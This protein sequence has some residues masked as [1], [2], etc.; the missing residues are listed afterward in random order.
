MPRK[1]NVTEDAKEILNAVRRLVRALRLFDKEAHSRYGLSTAQLFILHVLHENEGCSMNDL[2]AMT[3]TD[4]STASVIVQRLV[5]AGYVGRG[6]SE[7]D[8]R[9]VAL[10][11]TP[12]GRSLM[13]KSPVPVQ[14]RIRQSA[15]RMKAGDRT[16]LIALLQTFLHGMDVDDAEPAMLFE[17]AA[18]KRASRSRAK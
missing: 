4:Q 15:Q 12:S 13:A 3:A 2:A 7:R 9:H 8:R 18:P 5:D 1:Q 16:Q 6:T 11:L 17:E 14:E 10:T